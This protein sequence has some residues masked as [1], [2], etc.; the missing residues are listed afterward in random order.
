MKMEVRSEREA[1]PAGCGWHPWFVRS[2]AGADDVRV[3]VPAREYYERESRLPTGRRLAPEGRTL[4]EGAPLG[5]RQLDD[6]YT[7]LCPSAVTFEWPRLTLTMTITATEP[8]VQVFAT[9]NAVCV[10]PQTCPPDAF[11]LA[12]RG[13]PGTGLAIVEP[14]RPLQLGCRWTWELRGP[15]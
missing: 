3:R 9:D 1:F 13:L 6:C 14:G 10:E 15:P 5:N 2:F 4:L 8:H 12:A 7:G 11:G